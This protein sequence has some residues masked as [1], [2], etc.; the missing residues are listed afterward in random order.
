[1]FGALKGKELMKKESDLKLVTKEFLKNL[2]KPELEEI[3]KKYN[4]GMENGLEEAKII[5]ERIK[6]IEE[7]AL[8]KLKGQ[9]N[10]DDPNIA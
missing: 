4:F 5:R 7:K 1:M 2:S 9:P 3:K 10:G 8:R 6:E